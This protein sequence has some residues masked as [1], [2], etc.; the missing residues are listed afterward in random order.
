MEV[1][2]QKKKSLYEL[3]MYE[4]QPF[5]RKKD[6]KKIKQQLSNKEKEKMWN[7]FENE[8]NSHSFNIEENPE[9]V[10][11]TSKDNHLCTEC[12]SPV[13]IMEEVVF[14]LARMLNA[15]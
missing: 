11:A 1:K 5:R 3:G 12:Q 7:I 14:Q 15:E 4:S 9:C 2:T 10:Y 6:T 13:M 8:K